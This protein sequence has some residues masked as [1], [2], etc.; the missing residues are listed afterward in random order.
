VTVAAQ[1]PRFLRRDELVLRDGIYHPLGEAGASEYRQRWEDEAA[2]DHVRSAIASGQTA[3]VDFE[4][5][6][7]KIARVWH[8]IP[9]G[10]DLGVVLEIGSGYG[11]IPLF[12]AH[13]REI[14]WSAY[15]AVDIS[16]T[17]LRRL[18][19]YRDAFTPSPTPLYP[20]CVS[21]E[22]L[23][24]EDESVDTVLTSVVFL[25]MG[26]S[27]VAR[28]VREIARV[29]RPGGSIVFDASFPNALNPPNLLLRAKPRRLRAPNY[30][31]FWTRGEVES[32]LTSSGL[33]AKTGPLA[34]EPGAYALLPRRVGPV[35]IPLAREANRLAERAPERLHGLVTLTYTVHSPSLVA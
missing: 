34:V 4:T 22:Q 8:R 3:A 21:A 28:A 10:R 33:T 30:M 25:H 35:P 16:E 19:E 32:L 12:L 31:K 20:V 11:R 23:P 6:T 1:Q 13:E 2:A 26:K 5:L 7:G 9:R 17:M 24:L 15:C 14:A 27:F 29:L 18:V